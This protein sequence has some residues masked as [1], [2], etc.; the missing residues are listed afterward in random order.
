MGAIKN[1]NAMQR[2]DFLTNGV[3]TAGGALA[4]A[5]GLS[6][7]ATGCSSRKGGGNAFGDDSIGWQQA[8]LPYAYNALE[9]H[10]DAA[11]MEIHY[12]RHAAA[13]TKNMT[14]ALAEENVKAKNLP[15]LL[16]GISKYS[17]KL[18]NNAGGHYNHE[19]FWRWLHPGGKPMSSTLQAAIEKQ[20]GSVSD[21][22]TQFAT[23]ASSRFGSG[24]AWLVVDKNKQLVIGSTPNQD[25]PL[26]DVS[27]LKGIPIL[28]LDVWEHAYY[29]KYQNKRGDYIGAFWTLINWEEVEKRYRAAM[30]L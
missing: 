29:L 12:S 22:K 7:L 18:R 15:E 23:A 3:L 27:P 21:C 11:T 16:A 17:A 1:N 2:R 24:W 26:M 6:S 14:D 5:G 25:N 10:I 28:G 20:F 19:S 30:G 9:P 4:L 13:Y 8:P